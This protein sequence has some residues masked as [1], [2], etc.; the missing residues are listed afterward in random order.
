MLEEPSIAPLPSPVPLPSPESTPG[1]G[2]HSPHSGASAGSSST[3]SSTAGINTYK[4]KLEIVY[5]TCS[6]N[7]IIN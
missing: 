3:T 2:V 5:Q 6:S 1:G 7:Y 4:S